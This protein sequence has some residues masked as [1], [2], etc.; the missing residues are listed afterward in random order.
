[1]FRIG[2]L[3]GG[4]ISETHARAAQEVDGLELVALADAIAKVYVDF[5]PPS[6]EF[7]TPT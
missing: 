2:I 1:M 6:A 7:H 5:Q 4:G 3:G